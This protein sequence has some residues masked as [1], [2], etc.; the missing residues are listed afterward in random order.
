MDTAQPRMTDCHRAHRL[1]QN[2][3]L[4]RCITYSR[5]LPLRGFK[6]GTTCQFHSCCGKYFTYVAKEGVKTTN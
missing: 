6:R 5:C 3:R 1:K 4:K 2:E